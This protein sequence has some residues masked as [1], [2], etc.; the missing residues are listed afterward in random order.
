MNKAVV[1]SVS[2]DSEAHD[3]GI[4]PGD[5]I[6]SVNNHVPADELD[7]RFYACADT[8][9]LRVLKKDKS[10]EIIEFISPESPDLGIRFESA[11]FGN[12]KRCSNACIFC[13]IDQLP[14]GMRDT[15]YFKDDDARLSFLTGNY[16]T[17][18]NLRDSDIDKI[19][20]M[21]LEPINISI[22]TTDPALRCK[23]LR[24]RHAGHA[25]RHMK[26]LYDG[27]IHMN[28]QIVLV[29][30]V[31]DGDALNKTL[32]DLTEY[33]PYLTSVS[34]VPVGIT[35]YRDGLFPLT[36]F[37]KESASDVLDQIENWQ[38]RFLKEFGTRF[39]YAADEFY[40]LAERDTPKEE[41]YEGY[42]QIENGVGLL[43]SLETEFFEAME[44]KPSCDGR[45]I[46]IVT[47]KAAYPLMFR[48]S[49]EAMRRHPTLSIRVYD[50]TNHFFGEKITVAGLI[51]GQ[52]IA[53]Q[54]AGVSLGDAAY[55]PEVM[56]RDNTDVFLDDMTLSEL[57]EKLH[58]PFHTVKCN[59]YDLWDK[60]R[61]EV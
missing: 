42:A 23:M 50:I 6:E 48:L 46:S 20:K 18:T 58:V 8:V 10:R 60:L 25:L 38:K 34:V 44:Q 45:N 19:I 54:L 41:E 28:G 22:H 56:L 2:P 53:S 30:D 59:G 36:P 15:L 43:R 29:R 57:S 27:H 47:G 26:K 12:A 14:S 9:T 51:T 39:V 61:K 40:L 24:N 37:D 4:V 17:L 5:I 21:R 31:N 35:K 11:L 1:Y 33:S 32:Q 55:I 13:F 52:D 16:V 7:F 49:Q 3:A